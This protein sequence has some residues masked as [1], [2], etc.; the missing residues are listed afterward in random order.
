I[1]VM[2]GERCSLPGECPDHNEQN[3]GSLPELASERHCLVK[4]KLYPK[5]G[6]SAAGDHDSRKVEVSPPVSTFDESNAV[7]PDEVLQPQYSCR[8]AHRRGWLPAGLCSGQTGTLGG[9]HN[10]TL[11]SGLRVKTVLKPGLLPAI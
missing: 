10:E 7:S 6:C 9:N 4:R 5:P 11:A 3:E 1:G 8:R 2:L